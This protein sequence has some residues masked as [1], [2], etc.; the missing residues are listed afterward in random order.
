M[1]NVF[2]VFN[3]FKVVAD[4]E[5]MDELQQYGYDSPITLNIN[6]LLMFGYVLSE[7]GIELGSCNPEVY[8]Q[9]DTVTIQKGGF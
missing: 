4:A 7:I 1:D 3:V 6:D 2:N 8:I 5:I 9:N